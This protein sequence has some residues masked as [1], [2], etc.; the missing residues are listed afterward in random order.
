MSAFSSVADSTSS[1]FRCWSSH[2]ELMLLQ[3]FTT[4]SSLLSQHVDLL[5]SGMQWGIFWSLTKGRNRRNVMLIRSRKIIRSKCL[6]L[7][8]C[9]FNSKT[10]TKFRQWQSCENRITICVL[11]KNLSTLYFCQR[12][13]ANC[14]LPWFVHSESSG[15]RCR[16]VRSKRDLLQY[17]YRN[18]WHYSIVSLIV[19]TLNWGCS[20]LLAFCANFIV[21]VGSDVLLLSAR[22]I[23][24][25]SRWLAGRFLAR[26]AVGQFML[27]AAT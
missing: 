18:L 7:T 24:W 14:E 10:N 1:T 16:S 23:G 12:T 27:N 8:S 21:I 9:Y 11:C 2:G 25:T 19:S 26:D 17:Y 22:W 6:K 5:R 13:F 4:V 15:N 20:G 3:A